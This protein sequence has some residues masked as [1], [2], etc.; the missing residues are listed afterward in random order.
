MYVHKWNEVPTVIDK[1]IHMEVHVR[2]ITNTNVGLV[3]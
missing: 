1:C 3:E 2:G